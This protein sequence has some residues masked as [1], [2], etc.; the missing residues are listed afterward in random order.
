[1]ELT[2]ILESILFINIR[3]FH[4]I[5]LSLT[6]KKIR[7]TERYKQR[8]VNEYKDTERERERKI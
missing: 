5:F 1:M 2:K 8:Y 3:L 7:Q 4:N 6:W